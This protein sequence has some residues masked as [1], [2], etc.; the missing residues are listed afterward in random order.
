MWASEGTA[1]GV[2]MLSGCGRALSGPPAPT[3]LLTCLHAFPSFIDPP[4]PSGHRRGGQRV[5]STSQ[6]G[7][8]VTTARLAEKSCAKTS[9]DFGA[10]RP[11]GGH[12]RSL[13]RCGPPGRV[14][15]GRSAE[16][17]ARQGRS[18]T[19]SSPRQ[20]AD[21]RFA[22]PARP[23]RRQPARC[24]LAASWGYMY[25]V[26]GADLHVRPLSGENSLSRSIGTT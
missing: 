24:A 8:A 19:E 26:T 23:R 16:G 4:H 21:D 6:S 17:T 2:C 3:S 18:G 7:A 20:P 10:R 9:R 15:S 1:G 22:G 12:R 25:R 5:P 11:P 14:R 13:R